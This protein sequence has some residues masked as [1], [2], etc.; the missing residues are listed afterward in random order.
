MRNPGRLENFYDELEMIHRR[1]FPDW[2][3][4]QFMYNFITWLNTVK[5]VDCFVPEED[6][7][8]E[9]LR[10]FEKAAAVKEI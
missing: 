9:Y 1:S 4:G 5:Y 10:E 6:R 3:F 7:M 2:R 8:L